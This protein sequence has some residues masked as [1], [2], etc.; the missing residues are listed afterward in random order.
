MVER[1]ELQNPYLNSSDVT[2][3]QYL[4]NERTYMYISHSALEWLKASFKIG[5]I[6]N[7]FIYFVYKKKS[8]D[9]IM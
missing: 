8:F 5:N 4:Q 9:G 3:D 6:F 1:L 7:C 2:H